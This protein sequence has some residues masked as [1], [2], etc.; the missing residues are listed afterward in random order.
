MNR[1]F[2]SPNDFFEGS[3]A[4]RIQAAVRRAHESGC[5]QVV[6]P[7]MNQ[8]GRA[9][10]I[11]DQ[12]IELPSDMTVVLD[13]C[14]LRMADG[15]I[16]QMFRNELAYAPEGCEL[17]GEQHNISIVGRGQAIIDGGAENELNEFTSGKNGLP[18]V[19]SNLLIYMHNVEGIVIENLTVRD[20]RW[21]AIMF[22]F[23]RNARLSR[24]HFEITHRS[25]Y[26]NQYGKW[27]NQDGIDLRV[28]CSNFLIEDISGETGDDTI[29][30]TALCGPSSF[31]RQALVAGRDTDIHDCVIR[32]VRAFPNMCAIIRLL[33]QQGN[34][35]YNIA[36][37]NIVDASRPRL[38]SKT[39]EVLRIGED[40]YYSCPE[41][42]GH[43][44]DISNI[45]VS[46][47]YSRALSAVHLE[48]AVKNFH[49][50]NIFVHHDGHHA[51]TI[52]GFEISQ[53]IFMYIPERADELE[54][55]TFDPNPNKRT[56]VENVTIDHVYNAAENGGKPLIR[57]NNSQVRN[58]RVSDVAGEAVCELCGE[59]ELDNATIGDE[60]QIRMIRKG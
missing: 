53:F 49:A 48:M 12:A 1:E 52:G 46:N 43:P 34:K 16:S 60:G 30:L 5:N 47:V 7:R 41:D 36:M 58:L 51:L 6:I 56:V 8:A 25:S 9:E 44:G 24:L 33:C 29:A 42:R 10:W 2:F 11:I 28:G 3:D 57:I 4:Q 40:G 18:H 38:D 15:V 37:D 23:C 32:N 50:S 45:S 14:H 55:V 26:G 35:I 54:A 20:Q 19:S 13:N 21:W 27:R 39:Q 31:E 22:M 59:N 17:A